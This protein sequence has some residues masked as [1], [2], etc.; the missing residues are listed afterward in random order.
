MTPPRRR[1]RRRHGGPAGQPETP[2]SRGPAQIRESMSAAERFEVF[3]RH[4]AFEASHRHDY[5]ATLGFELDPF[6]LDAM[7]GVEDG[8]SVLVAAPTGAGKT[9]VGEFACDLAVS[10]GQRAFYT[11]P[12]KALSN[13]K[14]VDLQARFGEANV[15]LLTGDVSVNPGAPVVVMT[16][17]VLRNMI[18]AG[19]D[20]SDLSHVVLDE[21]H[22]LAD[23]F[24][25][26]VWEE[27]IIHLPSHVRVVAL[28]ATVSNAEEFGAWMREV[29]GSC[30]IV[31]S[32]RRP[33]PLYQHMMVGSVLFDLYAPS[34]N[35]SGRLNPELVA[36]TQAPRRPRPRG[37]G[38]WSPD[39]GAPA[40]PRGRR[41]SRPQALITLD[42][43]R[44]LPAIVFIFSRAGCDDAVS[45]VLAS[46]IVLT[47]RGEADRIR[48]V[49]EEA[50][51]TIP[52][53]DHAVLG[54]SRW[55]AGL[56]R[57]IAAHHAG[58]LPIMKETV[59]KLFTRGLVKV[60]YATET[61]ALGI[62]MPAR[63]VVIE[64]LTKWNGAAHVQLSAGEYTQLSGRAGR[65]GIDSEGH[66]VVL[67]R[68]RVA[69]EEVAAL[70]SRRTYPLVS[71]F[72]PTY[73]MVVNLLTHSS[74]AATRDVLETSFAQ[75][76]A[77]GAV[78]GL[79]RQAREREREMIELE[80]QVACELGD[81]REYFA[82]RDELAA[83]Q[84][85]R[86]RRRVGEGR[87]AAALALAEVR[88]GDVLAYRRGRHGNHA[89]ALT[90]AQGTSDAP[91]VQ[92]LGTDGRLRRLGPED[93]GGG[94]AVVGRLAPG[95]DL[96]RVRRARDRS[97]L[98]D[99]LRRLVRSGSLEEAPGRAEG[100]QDPHL[101]ELERR[102]RSHPVHQ[103]PERETH[104]VAGHAWMRARHEYERLA[105]SIEGR[106]NSVAKE[107]DRVCEVLDLLGFLD[108]G[109][110]T[111]AGQQ[112][113]RVFGERDLVV[114]EA[115]RSGA[116]DGL[117]GPELAA[118]AS[119]VIFEARSDRDRDLEPALPGGP[120]GGL[121]R[122]WAGTLAA[123]GRVSDAE[124]RAGASPTPEVE[125]GLMAAVHAWASGASLSTALDAADLQGGDFVRRIRQIMDL[126]DQLRHID[127]P[128]LAARA[129]A[130]RDLLVRGVVA[131][132][133]V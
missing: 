128:G 55:A 33:V 132:S 127:R 44:L 91:L 40:R 21:V 18:Y 4:Q 46:G 113:R 103:C 56:E 27:V 1:V 68:G 110:V 106:T 35:G 15:G 60:V 63:T 123:Q 120:R 95:T 80:S 116:W 100:G 17:E 22:Y 24:R 111:E 25:G 11:T 47:S 61:L 88:P 109:E 7:E 81:A 96:R 82:L 42:R 16:T 38:R 19:T 78:V 69:P 98:A 66:A 37:G 107:F 83:A 86:A 101:L 36:A 50:V 5:A 59:E 99:E 117:S 85:T 54:V 53:E 87:R 89:V 119:T 62:N 12:I 122:A 97:E 13:Q 29:R 57:G 8:D 126:L 104:A 45:A 14:Y 105:R 31:V 3:R 90:P 28:S 6:Q 76:Q 93:A 102:I 108:G 74:R 92:V 71:A 64:S 26:P 115:I 39:E 73:N 48:S 118:I 34:S 124:A 65:R 20:L 67:H 43:A 131:W 52:P 121:A 129:R 9:V 49:V 130:A 70:A 79:A 2:V 41:E 72:H 112:L 58:L 133:V 51:A 23:R 10:R 84:K 77:D 30:R 114:V 75:F 32:E 125:P 94:V